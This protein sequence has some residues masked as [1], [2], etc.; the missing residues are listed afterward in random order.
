MAGG[1]PLYLQQFDD[2]ISVDENI[3]EAFL[4]PS[5]I[6]YEE[7]VNLLKQE[8]QKSSAYNAIIEA[9]ASGKTENN[10]IATSAGIA[11]GDLTYY[12]KELQRIGLIEK[13]RPV[14]GGSRRPVCRLSDN[15]FRFW[16]RF[17]LP[18]RSAIERHMPQRV[19]KLIR[20]CLSEYM[21]PVFEQ[22]CCEWL[23]RQNAAGTLGDGFDEVGRWWGNS[24]K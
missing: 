18:N 14:C 5:S 9:V 12:L 22:I 1:V 7:P 10:E 16:Y 13:E 3:V 23:W 20:G 2:S 6:L 21:G 4:D 24:P 8:I 11:S 15:L 19:V 17:I